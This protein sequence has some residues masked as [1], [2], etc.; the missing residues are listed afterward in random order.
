MGKIR[1]THKEIT[2][3]N[4]RQPSPDRDKL[5]RKIR[6]CKAQWKKTEQK[7]QR[8]T[9]TFAEEKEKSLQ[10]IREMRQ[11]NDKLQ[12]EL[13]LLRQENLVLKEENELLNL[14]NK[15]LKLHVC[16]LWLRETV[17]RS[18]EAL[19]QGF[20]S[21]ILQTTGT[22]SKAAIC[23]AVVLKGKCTHSTLRTGF[24]TFG[25][26]ISHS[27][28]LNAIRQI[29]GAA[30]TDE[31]LCAKELDFRQCLQY[32]Q[33]YLL[34]EDVSGSLR[35]LAL[36]FVLQN[37]EM[38]ALE[39]TLSR[40]EEMN[41][42]QLQNELR[43]LCTR[44]PGKKLNKV[45]NFLMRGAEHISGLEAHGRIHT[46]IPLWKPL[47][48]LEATSKQKVLDAMDVSAPLVKALTQ[49]KG[50]IKT[51]EFQAIWKK[52]ED[53]EY[54]ELQFIEASSLEYMLGESQRQSVVRLSRYVATEMILKWYH[55]D[56]V[57]VEPNSPVPLDDEEET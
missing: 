18:L 2:E 57:K 7:M 35:C 37:V 30:E 56:G 15:E 41:A 19:F 44:L 51:S 27:E 6:K 40:V 8:E 29:V 25:F 5:V 52:Y 21:C 24:D 11:E 45:V 43:P 22:V 26:Y 23:S 31:H 3:T 38:E 53:L 16:P 20:W 4:F 32:Y 47:T 42:V 49:V 1:A 48:K 28:A 9:H 34:R 17:G 36:L 13:D 39:Q 55:D 33:P 12:G 46:E 14:E 54:D 10:I 50:Y